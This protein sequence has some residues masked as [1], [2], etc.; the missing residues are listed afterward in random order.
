[1]LVLENITGGY[2]KSDVLRE[3]SL[4]VPDN[5]VVALL[6]PNSAGK[7]TLLKVASGLIK[8]TRGRVILNGADVTRLPPYK[9]AKLGLCHIV[10]G[11]GIF[12]SLSVRENLLVCGGSTSD[13]ALL[14]GASSLFPI[15][16]KRLKQV[17]GTLSGGE[18]QMLALSRAALGGAQV[19]LADEVSLGLAPLV[20]D[21]IFGVLDQLVA[22]GASILLVEQY[23]T[24]ALA[25]A[26][27]VA[28]LS[29]GRIVHRATP[30]ELKQESSEALFERYL[31]H[32][33]TSAD[34]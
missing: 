23:V 22:R 12:P 14:E 2:D 10:E 16:G 19:I 28:I 11:R 9:R 31:A 17:A 32:A 27:D 25:M 18:Q 29:Q 1:L 5:S 8:P 6:G 21:A 7:S 3:V 33:P 15:L 24:R 34:L 30:A 26:Q 13:E 4:E 20:V